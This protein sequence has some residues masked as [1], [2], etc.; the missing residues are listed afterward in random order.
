MGTAT[1]HR[2]KAEHHR[3]FLATITDDYP[4][5]LATVAFYIAVERVEGLLAERSGH[6]KSHEDRKNAIR[7]DY[8]SIQKSYNSLYNASL[9]ARYE[10]S[11]QWRSVDRVRREL[12]AVRLD[13][14]EKFAASHSRRPPESSA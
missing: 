8:P 12:I 1:E 4:D 10:S 6:S 13:H 14:I 11:T 3:R 5:W 9:D 7:R 2:Q